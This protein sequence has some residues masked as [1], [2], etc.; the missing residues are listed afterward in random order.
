M[1]DNSFMKILNKRVI[2]YVLCDLFNRLDATDRI[3]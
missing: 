3:S 1:F 2:V